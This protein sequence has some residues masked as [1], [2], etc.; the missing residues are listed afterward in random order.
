VVWGEH[1]AAARRKAPLADAAD[2]EEREELA[3]TR[4][5]EAKALARD[6]KALHGYTRFPACLAAAS[7]AENWKPS[8]RRLLR[9][10]FINRTWK[11][12]PKDAHQRISKPSALKDGWQV[13]SGPWPGRM[14]GSYIVAAGTDR[15]GLRLSTVLR[16]AGYT[17]GSESLEPRQLLALL[18]DMQTLFSALG[19]DWQTAQVGSGA[20]ALGLLE[21]FARRPS[22]WRD[23]T[24]K[25][26]LP[27]RI[28]ESLERLAGTTRPNGAGY[29]TPVRLQQALRARGG[30]QEQVALAAGVTAAAVSKWFAKGAPRV[31][32]SWLDA[33]F[34]RVRA[35]SQNGST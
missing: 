30:S 34:G 22:N 6:W 5:E 26:Y 12:P 8:T 3:D 1:A 14:R 21:R 7:V 2:K 20:E 4:E 9:T 29:W 11:S 33:Y 18:K 28:Q 32:E 23:L 24:V 17:R 15:R 19:I 31:R 10:I 27:V 25:F 13:E 16:Q 35:T